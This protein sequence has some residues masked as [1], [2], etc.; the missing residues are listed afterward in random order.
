[1][2][3]CLKV[4]KGDKVLEIGTGSGYQAAIIHEM[5]AK[6]YT[7]ERL[8]ELS[9]EAQKLFDALDLKIVC[10]IGD[11]SIGWS[12]YAPYDRIIVTA[13]APEVPKTLLGQLAEGGRLVAPI[14]SLDIQDVYVVEKHGNEF[15]TDKNFGFKFVPLI[16]REGW[17]SND[18]K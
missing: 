10:K 3:E 4:K 8:Q 15:F 1:M 14:G 11:G 6:V 9:L 17:P 5:G 18:R 16:G 13:A 7:I 12:E 2:T